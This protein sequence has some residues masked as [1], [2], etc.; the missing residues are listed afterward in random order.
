M[1]KIILNVSILLAALTFVQAQ[2]P[3]VQV[4]IDHASKIIT[5]LSKG[6]SPV[7][8]RLY[9]EEF[10]LN[11]ELDDRGHLFIPMD[12][13]IEAVYTRNFIAQGAVMFPWITKIVDLRT[14]PQFS[15]NEPS[16][17]LPGKVVYCIIV[18]ARSWLSNKVSLSAVLTPS[19]KFSVSIFGPMNEY[20][21]SGG[22]YEAV[23]RDLQIEQTMQKD[24]LDIYQKIE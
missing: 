14:Y 10:D 13:P 2:D 11:M 16:D 8:V 17:G 6:L 5:I 7:T 1:S 18:D 12:K 24:C 23:K 19:T 9:A 4:R 3:L 15:F 21:G 22:G 20:S